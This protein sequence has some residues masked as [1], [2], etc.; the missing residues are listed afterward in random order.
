MQVLDPFEVADDDAAGVAEDVGDDEDFALAV[1]QYE[2]GVGGGGAVGAFGE[3]AAL[4]TAGGIAVD[5]L[6][7]G[8]G[9]QDVAF[10]HEH[11]QRI[12]HGLG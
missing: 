12:E 4:Q 5:G 8:G 11:F 2:V 1:I 10:L 3:D 6:F 9:D 7:H